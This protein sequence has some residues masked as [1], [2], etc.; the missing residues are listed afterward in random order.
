MLVSA[1]CLSAAPRLRLDGTALGPYSVAVGADGP[2]QT[3]KVSNIGDGAFNF[4]VTSSAAWLTGTYQA[5]ATCTSVDCGTIAITLA[6]STL[7]R[8]SYTGILTVTDPSAIDVPQTIT[9][10]VNMGGTVP[11][12][13][14]LYAPPGGSATA[15]FFAGNHTIAT[16]GSPW[17]SVAFSGAGSFGFD[18]SVAVKASAQSLAANV[19]NGDVTFLSS[20][21][22]PDNKTVPVEFHVTTD[23]IADPGTTSL[24]FSASTPIGANAKQPP[25]NVWI[26]NVGQGTLTVAD[27]PVA[28]DTGTWLSV[29]Y[30][31]PQPGGVVVGIAADPTGLAAG[32][33]TG[34]V[35][36]NSNAA[37]GPTV[38]NVELDVVGPGAGP[39]IAWPRILN[40]ANFTP[41]E[42]VSP[43][44]IVAVYGAAPIF[45]ASYSQINIQIPF[46][47]ALTSDAQIQVVRNGIASPI[48]TVPMASRAPLILQLNCLYANTC[49]A[50]WQQYGIGFMFA[51]LP[52]IAFPVPPVY[53]IP[54]T[55]AARVGDVLEFFAVGLG[56]ASTPL[57]T[58]AAAPADPLP[59]IV[60]A[61]NVCF[62]RFGID[63]QVCTPAQYSGATPTYV[64]LY[65]INVQI[66][67][68]VPT[69]D[70]IHMQITN[71]ESRSDAVL[72]AIQ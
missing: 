15:L 66:P 32:A 61:Y 52:A 62:Y 24:T 1:A 9:V 58:G 40:I 2:Q 20:A 35:T 16:P 8:G 68:N 56:Q 37:N 25:Q 13:L 46:E 7:T 45:Y 33:H 23:P 38:F 12:S 21:F 64:G 43:G 6:T 19:Y 54:G 3:V 50:P 10:T 22:A 70:S 60:P 29:A 65:Q 26:A 42:A 63:T 57:V 5:A 48:G 39:T 36:V 67:A 31:V 14:K 41:G 51:D 27:T 47:T 72:L 17:L 53:P 4:T 30:V 69:G 49:P 34:T 71:G 59:T 11:D 44:D 28:V 55:R 18:V